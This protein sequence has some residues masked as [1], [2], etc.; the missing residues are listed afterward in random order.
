[1]R[2][3]WTKGKIKA[4]HL[5]YFEYNA[6]WREVLVFECPGDG[7]GRR[8]KL[9][10]KDGKTKKFLH[11]LELDA[12]GAPKPGVDSVIPFVLDRLGGTRPIHEQGK[13]KFYAC[14]FGYDKFSLMTPKIAYTKIKSLI[15]RFGN[16]AKTT[17]NLYKSYDW[18]KVGMLD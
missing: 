8:G 13:E 17:N 1:M 9:K 12:E 7:S 5:V 2:V 11:G 4:G 16:D 10:T 6:K 3:K 18:F 15:R 14:N